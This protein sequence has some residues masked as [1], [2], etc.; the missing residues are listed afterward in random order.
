MLRKR[1]EMKNLFTI[2]A[3]LFA[4]SIYSQTESLQTDTVSEDAYTTQGDSPDSL[5]IEMTWEEMEE[6]WAEQEKK[7]KKEEEIRNLILQTSGVE[8]AVNQ[9]KQDYTNFYYREK[10]TTLLGLL[11]P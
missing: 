3:I 6:L 10:R 9:N 4:T 2:L 7:R 1:K 11:L 8:Q 5:V